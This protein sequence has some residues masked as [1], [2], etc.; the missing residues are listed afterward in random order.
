[1]FKYTPLMLLALFA[2]RGGDAP[3]AEDAD[4]DG[5]TTLDDCNDTDANVN[6]GVAESCN[7]I[8]DDCDGTIDDSATDGTTFFLDSDGDGF[9]NPA[10]TIASCD[11]V[12]GYVSDSTDC[13]DG[14]ADFHPDAVE[15]DCADPND[16]NCDGS[17]GFAD[18]DGD[19]FP[20]CQDCNDDLAAI[21]PAGVESCDSV[22]NDC[23]GAVDEAG[24]ANSST[25]FVDA[26]SDGFGSVAETSVACEAPTGFVGN[27]DDCND[28]SAAAAP[29]G[30][31]VCDDLDNDCDGQ[32][33]EPDAGDAAT[34]YADG[35]GD[36]YGNSDVSL[37]A[38]DAPTGFVSDNTDCNDLDDAVLPGATETCD[39]ID[40]NCTGGIDEG[41]NTTW[42]VDYDADGYGKNNIT[43]DAC[44]KPNGFSATS[45]DCDDLDNDIHPGATELCNGLDDDCSVDPGSTETDGDSDGWLAC[46][47][48]CDDTDGAIN[49]DADEI[50]YDGDD[51]DCDGGSDY[52]QDGDGA[53]RAPEGIDQNDL[54]ASCT[55]DCSDGS[56]QDG[57]GVTC[58]TILAEFPGSPDGQYWVDPDGDGDTSD[59]VET[60]CDMSYDGGGWTYVAEVYDDT[61]SPP[62]PPIGNGTGGTWSEWAEHDWSSDRSYYQSL[63]FFSL[64]TASGAEVRRFNTNASGAITRDMVYPNFAYDSV[65]NTT[66]TGSCNNL[67]GSAC[68]SSYD[69]T[70]YPPNFD[71]WGRSTN[72]NTSY[73]NATWNYHNW[74]SCASD[75]GLFRFN[76]SSTARPQLL[77]SYTSA[78]FYQG[79]M[80]R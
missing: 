28:A 38:C 71:G 35:D 76:G 21:N 57:A 2:C 34:W 78:E 7:G 32:I 64:L 42:Y 26:D 54:D 56:T 52:D 1:M 31:E 45:D 25:W 5:F 77:G 73:G 40:N 15:A 18:A 53:D 68:D 20:A 62:P 55:D 10:Q 37:V 24:A 16:Y 23:D 80:V 13:N 12:A 8:D 46:G 48:D 47:D 59:A 14:D 41:F 3:E 36:T 11:D 67:T 75:S 70:G 79:L 58:A 69:W 4:D 72:C 9:G 66:V 51:Q 49:P 27:A 33:D 74:A 22:D 17:V 50:W 6:P 19:G 30:S 63:D 29:G 39:A 60:E 61:Y 65:A 43:V 44:T